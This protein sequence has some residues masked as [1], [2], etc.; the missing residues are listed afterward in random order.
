[1]VCIL[2][3]L[4]FFQFFNSNKFLLKISSPNEIVQLLSN[5][6]NEKGLGSETLEGLLKI[7]PDTNEIE[8]LTAYN[9]E[10]DKLAEAE[11]F[12]YQLISVKK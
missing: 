1:M 4:F 7:L 12:L 10:I 9:G 3:I 6:N 5:K 11:K 2:I 8:L